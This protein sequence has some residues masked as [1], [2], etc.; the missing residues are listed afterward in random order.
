MEIKNVSFFTSLNFTVVCVERNKMKWILIILISLPS[1]CFAGMSPEE[2]R[3]YFYH[4][5]LTGVPPTPEVLEEMVSYINGE[6]E[7]GLFNAAMLAASDKNF[8]NLKLK[9]FIRDWANR[10]TTKIATLNDSLLLVLGLVRDDK[11]FRE[12]LY[13][14]YIYT[15]T[16]DGFIYTYPPEGEIP[17]DPWVRTNGFNQRYSDNPHY[18]QTENFSQI[19]INGGIL[20]SSAYL[21]ADLSL[22]DLN[23]FLTPDIFKARQDFGAEI[24]AEIFELRDFDSTLAGRG[25]IAGFMT[26]NNF[27]AEFYN[28]GTNRRATQYIFRNFLCKEFEEV[29]DTT[30]DTQYVRRDVDRFPNGSVDKYLNYCVGCHA[31]QD[32]LGNAF[33]HYYKEPNQYVRITYKSSKSGGPF[34]GI[35]FKVNL[36]NNYVDGYFVEN[37]IW[38]NLWVKNHNKS[39]GFDESFRSQKLFGDSEEYIPHKGKGVKELGEYLSRSGAF[40]SCM[41]RRMYKMVCLVDGGDVFK[42]YEDS[43][44]QFFHDNGYNLR[45]LAAKVATICPNFNFDN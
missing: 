42:Y 15:I 35:D 26:T 44:S 9:N 43:L 37:D 29:A 30:V 11:D 7:D 24:D 36:V 21:N 13:T 12:V 39:L 38:E 8:I 20:G 4:H 28:G 33:L 17:R 18:D 41:A 22:L 3:A 1:F 5:R 32:A 27:A 10:A 45:K 6:G 23:S 34:A 16:K 25:L 31:G 2:K 19:Y 40:R 14:D